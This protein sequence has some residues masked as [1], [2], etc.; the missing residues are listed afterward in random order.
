MRR[1]PIP[2]NEQ[3]LIDLSEQCVEEIH[4]L[5]TLHTAGVEAE[6]EVPHGQ[7][8]HRRQRLPVEVE[9]QHRRLPAGRPSAAA[10]GPLTQSAFVDEDDRAAFLA[11][12]FLIA[13]HFLLRQLRICSSSRSRA[14]PIGRCGLHPNDTKI[15]QT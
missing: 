15:F 2:D 7:P 13:G 9:L 10:M 11:G 4:D 1:K 8:R 14:F 3:G 5:R 6:V 12:F